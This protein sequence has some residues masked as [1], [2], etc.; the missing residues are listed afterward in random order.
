MKLIS[1]KILLLILNRKS[2]VW[3][4]T[5][6]PWKQRFEN[7]KKGLISRIFSIWVN[8]SFFHTV[9]SYFFQSLGDYP[10]PVW[11]LLFAE[12]TRMNP[13]KLEASRDFARKRGYPVLR[14]C[15]FFEK[16]REFNKKLQN[17]SV[18][19]IFSFLIPKLYFFNFTKFFSF[20]LEWENVDFTK[21]LLYVRIDHK[22]WIHE[23][24]RFFQV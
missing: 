24:F 5:K 20:A 13:E 11:L 15:K 14:H 10:D 2:T 21:Y 18:F 8:F 16:F 17:F 9:K 6:N 7:V 12:G 22:C 1:R 19:T 23:F 4:L 3:K